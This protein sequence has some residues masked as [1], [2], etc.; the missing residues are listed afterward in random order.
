MAG[1]QPSVQN[2]QRTWLNNA[3]ERAL[4]QTPR[5]VRAAT[6]RQRPDF[7]FRFGDFVDRVQEFAGTRTGEFVIDELQ[8]RGRNFI[9]ALAI[10]RLGGL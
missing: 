9:I 7:E 5:A 3:W 1:F 10:V 4:S 6:L 8:R 2:P